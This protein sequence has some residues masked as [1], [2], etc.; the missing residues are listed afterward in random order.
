MMFT[1][2]VAIASI[3]T[4][5]S[6]DAYY[7]Q[8]SNRYDVSSPD[9]QNVGGH[10]LTK[11]GVNGCKNEGVAF[12]ATLDYTGADATMKSYPHAA[13]TQNLGK[14]MSSYV[15]IPAVLN[16]HWRGLPD[17]QTHGYVA[18]AVVHGEWTLRVILS[19]RGAGSPGTLVGNFVVG[20][21][22]WILY[23]DGPIYSYVNNQ[24][25]P[26]ATT[27]T[28]NLISFVRHAATQG[29]RVQ[30]TL[31]EVSGGIYF[32]KGKAA[33]IFDEFAALPR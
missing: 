19:F 15:S 33:I 17:D 21:R 5:V 22:N 10:G 24:E 31:K 28:T 16:W 13:V 30:G 7:N 25:L 26:H 2:A 11:I 20:G 32:F 3:F 4:I 6:A 18:L 12:Y 8:C 29:A 27:F 9:W 14:P 23:R 1:Q